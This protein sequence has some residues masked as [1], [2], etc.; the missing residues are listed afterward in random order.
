MRVM[1]T[2]ANG[3]LGAR[4]APR[5]GARDHEVI[6]AQR[7]ATRIDSERIAAVQL[8]VTD[9]DSVRSAFDAARPQV[10]IHAAAMADVDLCER[11]PQLA[12]AV[13]AQGTRRVAEASRAHG[14]RLVY[15]STDYVFDGAAGP[16]REDDPAA[17]IQVYGR[18][19]LEGE[20]AVLEV[21]HAVV[22][23]TAVLFGP[24]PPGRSNLV[25]WLLDRLRRGESAPA[26][27]DQIG[28]PTLVDNLSDMLIAL[29]EA[30]C[31][32]VYHVAGASA[33]DRF[34]FARLVAEVFG[35]DPSRVEPIL[36]ATIPRPARR[37][38]NAGLL[39]DK[40]RRDVPAAIPLSAEQSLLALR[41]QFGAAAASGA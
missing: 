30:S 39:V 12:H 19:K 32:G 20:L 26:A 23:R 34:Q 7:R 8:D 37:P 36:S 21:P 18:S 17:P 16:Y 14:A 24:A 4:L 1:I 35:F 10:V 38:H 28:S 29:A 31:G 6:L 22:A 5:L 13:N 41:D 15:V 2:G 40:L 9:D 11:D 33:L 25:L 27:T 3:M